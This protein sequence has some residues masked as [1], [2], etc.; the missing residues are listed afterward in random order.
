MLIHDKCHHLTP[1]TL[2]SFQPLLPP[3]ASL[4]SSTLPAPCPLCFTPSSSLPDPFLSFREASRKRRHRPG[5]HKAMAKVGWR[6]R[7]QPRER[8]W[9]QA[10]KGLLFHRGFL[11]PGERVIHGVIQGGGGGVIHDAHSLPTAEGPERRTR[12]SSWATREAGFP[13]G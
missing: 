13:S 4:L 5:V 3:G 6:W 10:A 11:G 9:S 7:M 8:V 12:S 1:L 2:P